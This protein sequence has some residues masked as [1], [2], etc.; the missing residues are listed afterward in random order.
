MSDTADLSEH[1][2]HVVMPSS[3]RAALHTAASSPRAS[4]S[5]SATMRSSP[6]S[7]S[8]VSSRRISSRRHVSVRPPEVLSGSQGLPHAGTSGVSALSSSC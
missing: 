5:T 6:T 2:T 3:T 4:Y 1:Q 8:S 7:G